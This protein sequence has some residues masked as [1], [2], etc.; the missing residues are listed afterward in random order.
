MKFKS[1][2]CGEIYEGN[3][4]KDL[5]FTTQLHLHGRLYD[6]EVW[7]NGLY[8]IKEVKYGKDLYGER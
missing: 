8:R 2:G 4:K 3:S 6:L 1:M 5:K 7:N